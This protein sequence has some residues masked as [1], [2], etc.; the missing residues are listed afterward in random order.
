MKWALENAGVTPDEIDYINAHGP[1][2]VVGDPIETKAIKRLFG[3]R[4]YEV[5]VSSTK[6]MIGHALGG[7]GAIETVA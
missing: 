3:E 5:P 4:A 7:G 6:S 2:T 1:G